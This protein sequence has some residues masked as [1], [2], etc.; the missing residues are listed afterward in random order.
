LIALG[1]TVH[2]VSNETLQNNMLHSQTIQRSSYSWK[3]C[4]LTRSLKKSAILKLLKK[5]VFNV[6]GQVF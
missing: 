2:F 6:A 5:Q 3:H 1:I 4:S